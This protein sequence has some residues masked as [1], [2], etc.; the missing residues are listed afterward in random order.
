MGVELR[1]NRGL[2]YGIRSNLWVREHGGYWNIRTNTDA[3][4]VR[5]MVNGM[6]EEIEKV[7]QQGIT[8]EEL[9]KAKYRSVSLLSFQLRTPDDIGAKVYEMLKDKNPLD[10]FDHAKERYMA[11]TLE[12]VKRVANKYLDTDHY[13]LSVSGN[14]TKEELK[15]FE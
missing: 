2:C 12:D 10:H 7:Q 15:E 14:I 3:N 8:Q 1:D 13:I 4:N 5:E 6:L 11:V 9:D